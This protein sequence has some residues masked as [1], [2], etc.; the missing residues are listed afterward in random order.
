MSYEAKS[1]VILT[2]CEMMEE[3]I[4][5]ERRKKVNVTTS[6]KEKNNKVKMKNL[7]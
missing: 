7:R 5:N 6:T 4:L 2:K 1:N 3:F